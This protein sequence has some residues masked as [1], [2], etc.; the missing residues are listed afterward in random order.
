MGV[1][2]EETMN[3]SKLD[4]TRD[5]SRFNDGGTRNDDTTFVRPV[6]PLRASLLPSDQSKPERQKIVKGEEHE[7]RYAFQSRPKIGNAF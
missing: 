4:I 7:Y 3:M 6:T 2:M 1:M 5:R